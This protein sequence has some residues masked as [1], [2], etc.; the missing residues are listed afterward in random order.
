MPEDDLIV[1]LVLDRIKFNGALIQSCQVLRCEEGIRS[2]N[3]FFLNTDLR[4][5]KLP[6]KLRISSSKLW[7]V[8]EILFGCL[9]KL[10]PKEGKPHAGVILCSG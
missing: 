8:F 6:G 2:Q 9:L 10:L 4:Q 7:G 5:G 1:Y 3:H